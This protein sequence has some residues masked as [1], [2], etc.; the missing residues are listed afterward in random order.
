M[1]QA[2]IGGAERLI[3]IDAARFYLLLQRQRK[4]RADTSAR[5]IEDTSRR[6]SR[7]IE[8]DFQE[9]RSA[10]VADRP[11]GL[12]QF[13][14]ASVLPGPAGDHGATERPGGSI[15]DEAA[16]RQ[17][18]TE[19]VQDHVAGRKPAANSAARRARVAWWARAQRS[20]GRGKQPPERSRKAVD[21]AANGGAALCSAGSSA[22]R[23]TGRPAS[24]ARL[25]ISAG[26]TPLRRSA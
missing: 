13:E 23:S 10:A 21:E 19:G 22:L 4:R 6:R 7:R 11:I 15:E 12:D 18:I 16:G 1:H 20:D 26:S 25:V 3:G 17:M 9:I 14:L 8:Q 24:A 5:L 2:E